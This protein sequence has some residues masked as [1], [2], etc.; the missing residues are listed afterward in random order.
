VNARRFVSGSP[1]RH[2]LWFKYLCLFDSKAIV[3]LNQ[4]SWNL[5]G[6]ST[7]TYT[8]GIPNFRTQLTTWICLLCVSPNLRI[9]K[10]QHWLALLVSVSFGRLHFRPAVNQ[11]LSYYH[12]PKSVSFRVFL[13]GPIEITSWNQISTFLLLLL[14]SRNCPCMYSAFL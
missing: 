2:G 5:P 3:K 12:D 9:F 10:P 1:Q 11:Q 8:V 6:S 13:K 14:G 4:I 7:T